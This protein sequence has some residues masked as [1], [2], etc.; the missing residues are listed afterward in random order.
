M[1]FKITFQPVNVKT[2][3]LINYNYFLTS[4]IYRIIET[5]SE[6]Y[7]RFLHFDGYRLE[8]SQKNFKLFTYSR[9]FSKR[10]KVAGEYIT[11]FD[12]PIEWHVSSPVQQFI[13]HMVTGVFAKGQEV[14]I[15]PHAKAERFLV[16]RIETMQEPPSFAG[17]MSFTCLSPI[18]LSK[19]VNSTDGPICH[20]IRPDE[21]GLSEAIKNNL[22]KKYRL[23]TGKNFNCD[24]CFTLTLDPVYF[25]KRKGKVQKKINF[26]GTDI[27]GFE[28]PFSIT[29]PP[30]LIKIG[31]ETG[32]GEKGSMGFG[33]VKESA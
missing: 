29:A 19:T 21:E 11:F 27:I 22:I 1:R 23:I 20:Y 31:Y 2:S 30:E 4:L 12:S 7:S 18:T 3:L 26:K 24:S 28:A 5:S 10:F 8:D 17:T 9:L 15:G 25:E 33:M 13:E 16:Q 32:F 6:N 14:E